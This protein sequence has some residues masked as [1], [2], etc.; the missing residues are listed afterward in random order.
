MSIPK[1]EISLLS[2]KMSKKILKQL[3]KLNRKY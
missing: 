1:F 3:E 2:Q